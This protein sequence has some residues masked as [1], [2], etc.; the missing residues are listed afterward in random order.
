MSRINICDQ[1]IDWLI[2]QKQFFASNDFSTHVTAPLTSVLATSC[3]T[4]FPAFLWSVFAPMSQTVGAECN[5][6]ASA[7]ASCISKNENAAHWPN[8]NATKKSS[9][10]PCR[11]DR[12][13]R[14]NWPSRLHK[15]PGRG[16]ISPCGPA[17]GSRCRHYWS[18]PPP[19]TH[20]P[21]VSA[22][23]PLKKLEQ[24]WLEKIRKHSWLVELVKIFKKKTKIFF[25]F[26][27]LFFPLYYMATGNCQ[28]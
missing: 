4:N 9:I 17:H 27:L 11:F 19:C 13:R 15:L 23:K 8:K 16:P 25:D 7:S 21:A 1:L 24:K 18:T 12:P 28:K 26:F 22:G 6:A 10:T 14:R 3:H 20:T 5:A 2:G